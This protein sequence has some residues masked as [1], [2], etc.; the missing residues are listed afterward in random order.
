MGRRGAWCAVY[1]VQAHAI[2]FALFP[3]AA[4]RSVDGLDINV[5]DLDDEEVKPP[6]PPPVE[7]PRPIADHAGPRKGSGVGLRTPRPSTEHE[8]PPPAAAGPAIV[9][10]VAD[11]AIPVANHASYAGGITSTDSAGEQPG[12]E[13]EGGGG[14]G[15]GDLSRPARLGGKKH[16]VCTTNAPGQ[17]SVN[18]RVLVDPDG[19]AMRVEVLRDDAVADAIL[20]GAKPCAMV[21]RY[22]PGRDRDG[23]PA[24]RWT[25]PFRVVVV[26]VG[27]VQ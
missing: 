10:P 6:E 25:Q 5:V 15:T 8:Q 9:A 2:A 3:A 19:S 7:L 11:F 1:A 4:A 26:G 24:T 14:G 27:S 16:W 13:G 20:D 22:I 21:E 17:A 12:G 23:R 18:V